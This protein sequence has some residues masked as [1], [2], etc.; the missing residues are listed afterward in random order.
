MMGNPNPNMPD[1]Q[2]KGPLILG[3]DGNPVSFLQIM[4]YVCLIVCIGKQSY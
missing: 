2:P 1:D 4:L 3:A